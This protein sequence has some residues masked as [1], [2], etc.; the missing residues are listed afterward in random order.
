MSDSKNDPG[1]R[2]ESLVLQFLER[3][4]AAPA[5]SP[6]SFAREFPE[7]ES[8]LLE[9][10]AAALD[11]ERLLPSSGDQRPGTI[12]GYSV[13]E[14]IGRGGMG[15]VYRVEK[16]GESFALKI[17]PGAPLMG[18]RALARFRREADTLARLSDPGIVQVHTAGIDGEL[19]YIVMDFVQG[20]PLH[21]LAA[22]FSIDDATILVE[23]MARTIHTVHEQGIVHRDLKPQ[24]VLVLA[25]GQPVLVDFGLSAAS[26]LA[27]LTGTGDILGTPRYMAPEQMMGGQTD[28]RTDVHALGLILYELVTGRP[29]RDRAAMHG[30]V[31]DPSRMKIPAPRSVRSD[32]PRPLDRILRTALAQNP[33]RRYPTALAFAEDL[34]NFLDEKPVAARPPGAL[35][36]ATEWFHSTLHAIKHPPI[37]SGPDPATSEPETSMGTTDLKQTETSLDRAVT[38][39]LDGDE[40]HALHECVAVRRLDPNNATAALLE[41]HLRG[42]GTPP[43][44]NVPLHRLHEGLRLFVDARPREALERFDDPSRDELH[45]PL[46]AALLGLSA[47]Q[48]D[49]LRLAERELAAAA[50]RLP[51]CVR[52]H[53]ELGR[54]HARLSRLPEAEQV[55]LHAASLAPNSFAVWRSLASVYETQGNIVAG[56]DAATRAREL[57]AGAPSPDS[58]LDPET[59]RIIAS[60]KDQ[61]GE[62]DA[63]RALLLQL[64]DGDPGDHAARY[65][66][67]LSWDREHR[68]AQAAACYTDALEIDPSHAA[69]LINLAYL[70]SGA[71]RGKCRRCDEA[72]V[73]HP[74]CLDLEKA[75]HYLLRALSADRGASAVLVRTATD[76]ALRLPSRTRVIEL[77]EELTRTAPQTPETLQ[78]DHT[79]RALRIAE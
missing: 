35:V 9:A 47:A 10:I 16:N 24:N 70:Y 13:L 26:D 64:V 74:D 23:Q 63:A 75:E 49:Q 18:P 33:D 28:R 73:A 30:A 42:G 40:V 45:P 48:S 62:R 56:L 69:S 31:T 58:N 19:P 66:L 5:L 8:D 36:Q 14:E 61:A 50:R 1:Q 65:L 25:N 6:E 38:A 54:V 72:Y 44:A 60:L 4:E 37:S 21:T 55:L 12:A 59:Q 3:R 68:I 53:L 22:T 32:L 2:L 34:R 79:I 76:V 78:L 7:H 46:A 11:I 67:G 29:A 71:L 57:H 20:T 77:L 52:I 51:N 41:S 27:S 17:L 15:I 43:A 39:W